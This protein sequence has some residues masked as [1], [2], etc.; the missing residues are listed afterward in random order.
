METMI[1]SQVPVR[2]ESYNSFVHP[3]KSLSDLIGRFQ[4]LESLD[5]D[6]TVLDLNTL[7]MADN[8]NI[9]IPSLGEY[10]LTDWSRKQVSSL[11]GVMWDRWFA[12]AAPIEQAQ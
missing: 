10:A 11:V 4:D 5:N 6:D 1:N 2:L 9:A 3:S 7:R 8:G 12:T